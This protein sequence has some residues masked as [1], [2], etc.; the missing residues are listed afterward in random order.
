MVKAFNIVVNFEGFLFLY[1]VYLSLGIGQ[2]HRQLSL[3]PPTP[4]MHLRPPRL[5]VP[6]KDP[7]KNFKKLR[8]E[9]V[10]KS[11]ALADMLISTSLMAWDSI[12]FLAKPSDF[13]AK[14]ITVI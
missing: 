4:A 9:K 2:S 10:M 12:S 6:F 1:E 3:A 14:R 8:K 5:K 13:R 11:F 7:P